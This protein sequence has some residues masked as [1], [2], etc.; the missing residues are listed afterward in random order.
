[1][2]A[3]RRELILWDQFTNPYE[4]QASHFRS[5]E[6]HPTKT[7]SDV[8]GRIV[9]KDNLIG[10]QRHSEA[11]W[12]EHEGAWRAIPNNRGLSEFPNDIG[13]TQ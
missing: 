12:E 5:H 9:G 13:L 10:R 11:I 4:H 6:P 2:T 1:M 3:I 7:N 8:T